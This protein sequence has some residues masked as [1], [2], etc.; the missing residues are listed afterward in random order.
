[1]FGCIRK[2]LIGLLASAVSAYNHTKCLFLS[3][4]NSTTQPTIIDLHPH[5]YTQGLG[6]YQFEVISDICAEVVILLMTCFMKY[7][8]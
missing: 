4:Q 5:K 3:N 1:M 6:H 8:F 2:G 7:L